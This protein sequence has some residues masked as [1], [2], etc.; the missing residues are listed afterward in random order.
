MSDSIKSPIE[1]PI[2]Q[3]HTG[4]GIPSVILHHGTD[5]TNRQ[6]ELLA[7]LPDY[8][9]KVTVPRNSVN[10]TDLSALTAATGV[11]FAMFTKGQERLIIRGNEIKVNVDEN[12]AEELNNQGYRW[13]GHT[14]LGTDWNCLYAS[15]GDYIILNYFNQRTSVIYNS[16]G[17]FSTFEK[18]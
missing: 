3:Q 4:K 18:R 9:S 1:L 8:D 11:E 6:K 7:Q 14:H 10:M 15:R 5:L 12:Y 2:E 17:N 13:S 16:I